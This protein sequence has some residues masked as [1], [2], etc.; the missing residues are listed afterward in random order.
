MIGRSL[1]EAVRKPVTAKD[2]KAARSV[3]Q[4]SGLASDGMVQPFDIALHA[5]EAVGAAGLLGSGRT[6]TALLMFGALFY[7]T[8]FAR[9]II[10]PP[11]GWTIAAICASSE[12]SDSFCI[13]G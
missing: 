1:E 12:I 5:G 10:W 11:D 13:S 2:S 3:A 7:L 8:R 9:D 6:E 4:F